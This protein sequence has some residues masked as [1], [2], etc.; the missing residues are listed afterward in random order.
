VVAQKVKKFFIASTAIN[1]LL[2]Y[3]VR[4]FTVQNHDSGR[5]LVGQGDPTI[6]MVLNGKIS[7]IVKEQIWL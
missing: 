4:K 5:V 6:I 1:Y 3:Y 2:L 7:Y